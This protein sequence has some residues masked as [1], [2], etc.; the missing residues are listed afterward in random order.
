MNYKVFGSKLPKILS[1]R[2]FGDRKKFGLIPIEDDPCWVEWKSS[3]HSFYENTQ[4]KGIGQL[5]NDSGYKVLNKVKMDGLR[6]LEV[7]PGGLF[8]IKDWQGKPEHYVLVDIDEK[9]LNTAG[10]KLEKNQVSYEKRIT[11]RSAKGA[12]PSEENEFDLILSFYSFEHLTPF[13]THL[14]E[15][16]RILKPGGKIIGAIPAEGGLAWGLGRYLTSRRWLKKNTTLNPDKIICWEHPTM[17]DEILNAMTDAMAVNCVRFWP[18]KVPVI[19]INLV[20]QFVF[21]KKNDS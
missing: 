10:E 4:K 9:F 6:V 5:V 20:I 13:H 16:L 19:D 11:T 7:G 1:S 2:L 18:L 17:A 14:D 15:M 8:H 21:T 12:L 3:Y